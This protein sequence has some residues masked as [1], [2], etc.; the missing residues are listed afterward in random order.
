MFDPGDDEMRRLPD[1]VAAF[2]GFAHDRRDIPEDLRAET[3]QSVERWR[4][5]YV[6]HVSRE[7]RSPG[8][9]AVRLARIAAG[10]DLD[11][12]DDDP[13]KF[14]PSD[15]DREVRTIARTVLAGVVAAD[16]AVF[17]R[18]SRTHALAEG[19]WRS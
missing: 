4:A 11:D 1:V 14:D 5:D 19:S 10:L 8:D 16:P 17:R 15:D 13:V 2:A 7:G 12:V 18:S 9:H 3:Q 6:R